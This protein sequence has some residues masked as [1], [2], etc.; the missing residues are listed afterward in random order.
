MATSSKKD[1]K[2]KSSTKPA[3][4]AEKKSSTAVSTALGLQKGAAMVLVQD[5]LPDHIKQGTARGSENVGQED[6]VIPRLEIVQ[7]LSPAVTEGHADFVQ[8][9]KVGDMINSVTNQ[10]Y[11]REVFVV[12]VHYSKQY[13][14]WI[15]RTAG[16]GFR[17]AF[18]NPALADDRMAEV[19]KED[20]K[21]AEN[22]EVIDTPTH[23]CLI[24]NREA[25]SAEEIILS[26][27]RTKAKISRSWNSMVRLT[28]QDRFARVYRVA[29]QSETNAKGTFWNFAI[30]QSGF[31]V[32]AL[33]KKAE[34]LFE[35][36][37][38]GDRNVVMDVKNY[39]EGSAVDENA[40][41]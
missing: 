40:E 31:P 17:G 20:K 12:P 23:L 9:A 19:L 11:G 8:G 6:L 16:G 2:K 33:Y 25:G 1:D 13:L 41:M 30:A 21:D 18:P 24:I 5:Q 38:K 7:A 3:E 28:N 14:V 37:S 32:E 29:S 27:P 34:K 26:M 39:D 22:V 4:Q 36:I 10:I 15:K 35:Q